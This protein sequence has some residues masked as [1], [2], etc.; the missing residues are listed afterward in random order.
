MLD[1]LEKKIIKEIESGRIRPISRTV[2]KLRKMA[3]WSIIVAFLFLA[4]LSL[5]VLILVIWHGDWDIY[6]FLGSSPAAFFFKAFPYFWLL[7]VLGF[8]G[9]ALFRT[10]QT[11]GAYS[12][13]FVYHGLFGLLTIVVLASIFY[14]S[15]F[16]E[17]VETYLSGSDL[18]RQAN[19]LRSSWENPEKGLMAGIIE[20]N[21][22]NKLVLRDFSNKNWTLILPAN[23]F[24]G[25]QLLVP[26][27][28]VKLIGLLSQNSSTSSVFIVEQVRPWECGCLHCAHLEES[29]SGTCDGSSCTQAD[30]CQLK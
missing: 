18:Y 22:S 12:R 30:S 23:D 13:P 19:Y 4:G 14:Y 3:L 6:R 15:G 16:S 17:R 1:N 11:D 27:R 9:V 26:G 28:K 24:L 2:F 20:L 7:G 25:A 5:S 8:L 21:E 29:C 10:R